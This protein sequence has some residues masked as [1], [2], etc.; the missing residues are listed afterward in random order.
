MKEAGR[1]S[2]VLLLCT[3][4]SFRSLQTG[5]VAHMHRNTRSSL[6][7]SYPTIPDLPNVIQHALFEQWKAP[8]VF[9]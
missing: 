2:I 3:F 7:V 9:Q 8:G 6:G 5:D 4:A 1:T